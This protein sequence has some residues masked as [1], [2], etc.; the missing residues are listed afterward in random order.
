MEPIF[1][2][3]AKFG[4]F[5]MDEWEQRKRQAYLEGLEGKD[6]EEILR[7]PSESKTNPQL[8]YFHGVICQLA[9]E[10]SGY[11]R[12][13]VK[14]LLKGYYLTEYITAPDGKEIPWVPSLEDMKKDKMSKFIDDCIILCAKHWHCV[15]PPPED[16]NY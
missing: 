2:G 7:K 10:T 11:T 6:L 16:V 5:L 4:C 12:K 3:K 1:H 8:A 9:S 14:G 13:E 15:I